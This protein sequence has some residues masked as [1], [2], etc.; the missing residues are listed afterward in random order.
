MVTVLCMRIILF[1]SLNNYGSVF[2]DEETGTER[3]DNSVKGHKWL[4]LAQEF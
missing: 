2:R 1:T 3:S 4:E